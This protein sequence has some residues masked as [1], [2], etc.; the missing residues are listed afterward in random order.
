MKVERYGFGGCVEG[1]NEAIGS[2]MVHLAKFW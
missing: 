2:G 1:E